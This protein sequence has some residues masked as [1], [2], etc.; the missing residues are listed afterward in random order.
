MITFIINENAT[1]FRRQSTAQ[2]YTR[3][4]T[5]KANVVFKFNVNYLNSFSDCIFH[6]KLCRVAFISR[7][8]E[9]KIKN[10]SKNFY[11][12][13]KVEKVSSA[14]IELVLRAPDSCLFSTKQW[15]LANF[16][17]ADTMRQRKQKDNDTSVQSHWKEINQRTATCARRKNFNV[18]CLFE[19]KW[20]INWSEKS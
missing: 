13:N 17:I 9:R 8:Q 14:K 19:M 4:Q 20:R 1:D 3:V 18:W 6:V 15:K 12:S 5:H 2:I 10:N 11:S 7:R 16:P